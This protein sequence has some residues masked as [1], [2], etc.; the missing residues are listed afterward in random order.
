[1]G[2]HM[3]LISLLS[4][5]A[6]LMILPLQLHAVEW[7][8]TAGGDLG[9]VQSSSESDELRSWLRRGTGIQR[10]DQQQEHLQLRQAFIE[11]E[12][13][14]GADWSAHGTAFYYPDGDKR[15]GISEL[16][17]TYNPLTPG[18]KHQVKVGYFYPSMSFEN[19]L[20]GWLSPYT[21]SFSAINSW[22]G[23]ELKTIG[24]EWQ[25]TW[26]AKLRRS[27]HE[28]SLVGALF[29]GNDGAGTQLAWRGWAVHDRQSLLGERIAFARYRSLGAQP[30]W[31]EPF[32]ETDRRLGAYVGGHWRY[33]RQTQARLYYY[34]N[35]AD[36][37]QTEPSGQ[38]A[39]D[40]TFHS[41]AWMH[42][43]TPKLRWLGQVMFG[44]TEMGGMVDVDFNS[45]Y[46]LLSYKWKQHRFSVRYD[47]FET[48]ERDLVLKDP[49]SSDGHA[50]AVNWRY[51]LNQQ[52]Q[53]G[54]EYLQ[55]ESQN[56]SRSQY[57]SGTLGQASL[58]QKQF[59]ANVSFRY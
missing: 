54:M 51:Q 27:N 17:F 39:W 13:E 53:V 58:K 45:W 28:W 10:W 29:G 30:D 4:K 26:P 59:L 20:P 11:T 48:V 33:K 36:S 47:D 8:W 49:N 16:H 38:Y 18:L 43:F 42:Q 3:R 57:G 2:P 34:D 19:P 44:R 31:V 55:T 22:V 7:E 24:L 1:M 32:H 25:T 41:L 46:S 56:E 50:W 52:F 21:Y 15:L 12:V 35:R 37:S 40:T 14:L 9:W 5:H 23:E 6:Y